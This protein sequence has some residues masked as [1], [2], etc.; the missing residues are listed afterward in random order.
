MP[1]TYTAGTH[2]DHYEIIRMLGHGG[3]N[4]VYLAKDMANG[5]EVVLK[6]PNDD[7]L[8]NIAVFERY[9]RDWQPYQSS[10]CAAPLQ[11]G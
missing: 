6:I 1:M 3:M 5:Q 2:I 11:R 4:R 7:I 8:G 10:S 9:K